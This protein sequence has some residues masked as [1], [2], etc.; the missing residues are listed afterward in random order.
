MSPHPTAKPVVISDSENPKLSK[1]L[2]RWLAKNQHI[3]QNQL[4]KKMGWYREFIRAFGNRRINDYL[5]KDARD[6]VD[7][8]DGAPQ[9]YQ[10]L[11]GYK[12]LNILEASKKGKED[13]LPPISA[14]YANKKLRA[15]GR[16]RRF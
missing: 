14:Y 8:L 6:Y 13:G 2:E 1:A 7:A 3:S 11:A 12:R 9:R 10:C 5:M 4:D 15:S 16:C